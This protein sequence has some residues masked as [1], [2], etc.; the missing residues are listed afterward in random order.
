MNFE[1]QNFKSRC[2]GTPKVDGEITVVLHIEDQLDTS[3]LPTHLLEVVKSSFPFYRPS[4]RLDRQHVPSTTSIF[5]PAK[6]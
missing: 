4:A 2:L 5:F 1:N 6:M 3:L